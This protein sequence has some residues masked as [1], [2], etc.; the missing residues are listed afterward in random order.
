MAALEDAVKG[1]FV[2]D[3]AGTQKTPAQG[4]D[5]HSKL[6]LW[7]FLGFYRSKVLWRPELT[8]VSSQR[9]RRELRLGNWV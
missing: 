6:G 8:W 7:K 4:N 5:W 1:E 9:W 2:L 3:R